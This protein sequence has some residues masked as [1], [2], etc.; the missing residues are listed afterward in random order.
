MSTADSLPSRVVLPPDCADADVPSAATS[1]AAFA[2]PWA[3]LSV[4]RSLGLHSLLLRRVVE[5]GRPRPLGWHPRGC[6]LAGW[7]THARTAAFKRCSQLRCAPALTPHASQ[8]L[9]IKASSLYTR[10]TRTS[11]SSL[12]SRGWQ[13]KLPALRCSVLLSH[14][15]PAGLQTT[16]PSDLRTRVSRPS[17]PSPGVPWPRTSWHL[18]MPAECACGPATPFPLRRLPQVI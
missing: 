2:S 8:C 7:S 14:L 15:A 17:P 4:V 12:V 18:R 10:W 3:L 6:R 11:C 1:A 13:C 5:R 9:L 16:L